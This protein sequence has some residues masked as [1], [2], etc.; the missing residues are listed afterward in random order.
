MTVDVTLREVADG[1][2]AIFFTHQLDPVASAMAAFTAKDP[3]DREAFDRH[4]RRILA[5]PTVIV[6]TV[7]VGG[8]VAGSVSSYVDGDHPEVTYWLGRSFWGQGIATQALAA[9]LADVNRTRPIFARAARDNLG[10]LRVLEKCGFAVVGEDRGFANA[11]GVEIEE[12]VL[13]LG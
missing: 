2:L 13:K 4:W 1:D 8:Q 5:D 12:L 7:M 3:A 9:F 11:R 10:S 6:R